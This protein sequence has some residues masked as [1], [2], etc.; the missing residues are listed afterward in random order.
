ML[1]LRGRDTLG[2]GPVP[3]TPS[4]VSPPC[5]SMA[6]LLGQA[7]SQPCQRRPTCFV[8]CSHLVVICVGVTAVTACAVSWGCFQGA[9]GEGVCS[10]P[11]CLPWPH[12]TSRL[13]GNCLWCLGCYWGLGEDRVACEEGL[14]QHRHNEEP[15][16]GSLP[17]TRHA[18]LSLL[19]LSSKS[20]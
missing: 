5:A 4:P 10:T 1:W 3:V 15:Q 13:G 17:H 19:L 20:K 11:S 18:A 7:N 14:K 6:S 12:F 2:T 8:V 16:Q 9:L